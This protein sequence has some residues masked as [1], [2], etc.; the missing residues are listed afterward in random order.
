MH[1]TRDVRTSAKCGAA[2]ARGA[3]GHMVEYNTIDMCHTRCTGRCAHR[4]RTQYMRTHKCGGSSGCDI[5]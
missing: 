2:T 4:A 3:P 1:G 5:H